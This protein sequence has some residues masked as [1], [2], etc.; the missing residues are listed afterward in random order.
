MHSNDAI[1]YKGLEVVG[2]KSRERLIRKK[3]SIVICILLNIQLELLV[4]C[5]TRSFRNS[6]LCG[7]VVLKPFSRIRRK[8]ILIEDE[9]ELTR[10]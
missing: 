7:T 10:E 8:K 4:P 3:N 5:Y 9:M 1:W 6:S 2:L